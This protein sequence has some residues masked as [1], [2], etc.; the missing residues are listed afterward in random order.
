MRFM[1][2]VNSLFEMSYKKVGNEMNL[3]QNCH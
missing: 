3:T 2:G 1:L